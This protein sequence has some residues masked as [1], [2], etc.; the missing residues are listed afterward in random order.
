MDC[1]LPGSSVRGISQAR[2]L[3]YQKSFPGKKEIAISFSRESSWPRDRTS[4]S[5]IDRHILYHQAHREAFL[6]LRF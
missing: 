5:C 2:V 4:I 3:D 1:G 6:S